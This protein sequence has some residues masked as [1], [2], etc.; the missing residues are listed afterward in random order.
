MVWRPETCNS[1]RNTTDAGTGGQADQTTPRFTSHANWAGGLL[2]YL[3]ES[4]RILRQ[5][6]R[7][8]LSRAS[9]S[10]IPPATCTTPTC[11]PSKSP[12]ASD[13]RH[14]IR[15]FAKERSIGFMDF[16]QRDIRTRSGPFSFR[17]HRAL[18]GI[19]NALADDAIPRIDVLK[20]TQIGLT[21]LAGFGYGLWEAQRGRNVGVFPADGCHGNASCRSPAAARHASGVRRFGRDHAARSYRRGGWTEWNGRLYVRGLHSMLGA[22][23]VPLDVNLMTR[24]DDP[25]CG[26]LPCGRG[27]GSTARTTRA[28]VAFACGRHPGEG[29][30][31]RSEG[32]QHHLHVRC[33]SCGR[34]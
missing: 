19:A 4:I 28:R 26:P 11:K 30:D 21:T 25:R 23:S 22:I 12:P 24:L 29:I 18:I 14:T 32:T 16:L 3:R 17:G 27:N 13:S 2:R 33:P 1:E 31:A 5:I 6:A 7:R 8:V 15:H 9:R 20:A 10:P 34:E